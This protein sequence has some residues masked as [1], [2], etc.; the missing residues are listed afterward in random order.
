MTRILLALSGMMV[1]VLLGLSSSDAQPFYQ[2]DLACSFGFETSHGTAVIKA[3]S[4][5]LYVRLTTDPFLP[6]TSFTCAIQCLVGPG[7]AN[8][9][10]G[11][12]NAAGVL[13]HIVP[14]LGTSDRLGTDVCT[15]PIVS[16]F[17]QVPP[18]IFCTSGYRTP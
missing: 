14:R 15:A 8:A 10:C 16:V 3:S 13:T 2:S 18:F 6:N 12:T 17:T 9:P 5:D 1:V 7:F 11:L 4:G